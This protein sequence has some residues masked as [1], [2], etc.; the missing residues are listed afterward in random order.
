[1]HIKRKPAPKNWPIR[2]NEKTWTISTK[3]G[4]HGR[5][6]SLP[7]GLVL[8][9]IL[10]T[11]EK[12]CEYE[13]M[14]KQKKVL[15]DGKAVKEWA[16]PVGLMDTITLTETGS[17]YRMLPTKK[18]VRPAES[19]DTGKKLLR[20]TGITSIGKGKFQYNFHDGRN[21][22]LD[23]KKY[24]VNDVVEYSLK[25]RKIT[26]HHQFKEGAD[27]L[28]TNGAKMGNIGKIEKIKVLETPWANT[29]IVRNGDETYE[30][31]FDYVFVADGKT[32]AETQK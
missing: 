8:R 30:T 12:A 13:R 16:Y 2:R 23:K 26:A 27:A 5:E 17:T 29:V 3:P 4:P 7:L 6:D 32:L 24:G 20:I 31:I 18:G 25:D 9:D 21:L 19:K 11:A 1:M 22:L 10:K 15:V 14:L 28:I